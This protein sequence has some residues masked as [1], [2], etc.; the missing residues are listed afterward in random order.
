MKY[1]V[2][3]V[4]ASGLLAAVPLA[5]QEVA[6]E[7]TLAQMQA[8]DQFSPPAQELAAWQEFAARVLADPSTSADVAAQTHFGLGV[9]YYYARQY[10]QGWDEFAA[11]QALLAQMDA[12]PP[13][14]ARLLA[15]G[16]MMLVELNRIDEA[17]AMAQQ[18]FALAEAGGEAALADLALAHNALGVLAFADNDLV[19]AETAFC[20]ARDLGMRAQVP[21][22]AM[23][24]N[25]ASSCGAVKYYLERRDTVEAARFARD[26]ASA[27]LPSDHPKM[28]NVL[29]IT[30][31]VLVSYGR[32][33]EAVPLIRRHLDLERKLR[34]DTDED[35]Y[36]PLSML[37]RS[38]E[39]L[40][41][42]EEAEGI[43]RAAAAIADNMNTS[44]QPYI[45][46][47]AHTNLARAIARQ[48]RLDEAER[49]AR[50]GVEQLVRD[51][52]PT[53]FN[54]GSGQVQ[55]A[56]HLARLGRSQ[57]A[58]ALTDSALPL[59]EAGLPEGHSEIL[60]ARLIR[61]RILSDLG[62]HDEA[63]A[64]A[65]PTAQFFARQLFDVASSETELVSL[66]Q[67]LPEALGDYL[68]VALRAG[69]MDQAAEAAQLRLLS[70]LTLS[71]ARIRAGALARG[72]GL[73][74]LLDALD[75]ARARTASLAAQMAA[76]QADEGAQLAQL[77]ANLAS[78]REQAQAAQAQL[79]SEFPEYVA[80]ARPQT[81]SLADLQA[82]LG[83]DD[84]LVLPLS[85][86]DRAVTIA[87][88][89]DDVQWGEVPLLAYDLR[90]LADRVRQS[91]Q[92]VGLFD[93]D[94]AAQLYDAL[95]APNL[96]PLLARKQRLLF[97]A[98]GY[99]ARISPA[100]LLT[101]ATSSD[102]LGDAPWL[103]RDHSVKVLADL[104]ELA[105][106]R[107]S[108]AGADFLGVG[109]PTGLPS[110]LGK[111]A[112]MSLP[113]LP[114][115][116]DELQALSAALGSAGSLVLS[117][118]DATE[119]R[120]HALELDRYGV[121]AFATHGLLGGEVPGLAEPAL[122]LTPSGEQGTAGDGLLTASEIAALHLNA[123]WVILSAC[124]TA[125]GES[126]SAPG[127]S[128]LARAFAQAGAHS[129]MLSHWRVRDDA[130]AYLS[131]ETLRRAAAGEDRGDALRGAQLAMMADRAMPDAA[132]PAI[133]APFVIVE[134]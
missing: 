92:A 126:A 29:N 82:T 116:R 10:P 106:G 100:M 55:L 99:L 25:D 36:D 16:S 85:L 128:G 60:T 41:Q 40:G 69:A 34:G 24:V 6:P 32:Y 110:S 21:D 44:A 47:I 120:L 94:A 51:L 37:A 14:H 70:E 90:T 78:A 114:R 133:W 132:H 107:T 48:G 102:D 95:F 13:Y 57:E 87:I 123:D 104:G 33:G 71:N 91:A 59:L 19:A 84:L 79:E 97:P 38:L 68:L 3:A 73:G 130:A 74:S 11:A 4:L 124:E 118:N 75:A 96:R 129:L 42:Y 98:S 15:Y 23:I 63:V 50:A 61:A 115:A 80:L 112:A 77:A 31:A 12:S 39:Q 72:N 86:P 53:N 93:T 65:A 119:E 1:V 81:A 58:L 64:L 108:L 88:S 49:E 105:S 56:D 5:A 134:N 28:G 66:S 46:G 20:A 122:L 54:I 27:H 8:R 111:G 76:A 17:Q 18:A 113:P 127:Y 7:P 52:E 125:A 131:V 121:I 101:T 2:A 83:E 103:L 22:H 67:V 62:R 26:Y 9:A 89:H 35:I 45:P 117:G 109:A 30:Y 43:F